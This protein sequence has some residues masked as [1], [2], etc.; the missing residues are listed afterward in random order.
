MGH[1]VH[2]YRPGTLHWVGEVHRRLAWS[3]RPL[4]DLPGYWDLSQD[5]VPKAINKFNLYKILLMKMEGSLSPAGNLFVRPGWM[6]AFQGF[7]PDFSLES[8]IQLMN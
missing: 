7:L 6:M 2:V 3:C 8:I 4:V 5:P 1:D